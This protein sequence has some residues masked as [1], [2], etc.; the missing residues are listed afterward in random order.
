[1][2]DGFARVHRVSL[3]PIVYALCS[4]IELTGDALNQFSDREGGEAESLK[5]LAP[6]QNPP[7]R[8]AARRNFCGST[9]S[10]SMRVS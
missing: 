10:P 6:A 1:M 9:A 2:A 5:R 8:I 3:Y 7:S 4:S